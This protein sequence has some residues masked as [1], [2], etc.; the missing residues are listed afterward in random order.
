VRYQWGWLPLKAGR[1][2][3]SPLELA[4]RPL[5]VDH[6]SANGIRH[7]FSVE[8]VKYTTARAVAERVVDQVA[9]D[10]GA[11]A[12][13]CR[14]AETRL[15]E[16]KAAVD[17]YSDGAM[18]RATILRAI[19]EEMALKLSDIV[20]RRYDGGVL[21]ALPRRLVAEVA[22]VASSEL[23]WTAEQQLSE[24]EE[25]LRQANSAPTVMEPTG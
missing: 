18:N 20:L 17:L 4:E 2:A 21:P 24:I 25:V 23:G 11:G 9:R 6:G 5:I 15:V 3:G 22:E 16:S 1:E 12:A 13:A 7:L 14:T 10:L 8:G 19:R